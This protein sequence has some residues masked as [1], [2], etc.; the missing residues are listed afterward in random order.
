MNKWDTQKKN[1]KFTPE[2]AACTIR[3]KMKFLHYAPLLFVSA[4][5]NQGLN[6]LSGLLEEII[7]QRKFKISTHEFTQWV[8]KEI[9][10]NNPM[11]AKVYLAHQVGKNPPT[12]VCH[13][14]DPKKV[15]FSLKR[16][17]INVLREKWGYMGS[18]VR[19]HFILA[20]NRKSLPK[21][22]LKKPLKKNNITR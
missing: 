8:R 6:E 13:V 12:F 18:P 15:H 17:L 2:M 11:N 9:M 19:L 14:N 16:H 21:K 20:K 10:K 7:H 22:S 3:K 5:K 4:L 1:I